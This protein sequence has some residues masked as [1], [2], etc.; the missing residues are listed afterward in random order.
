MARLPILVN[1]LV[2][3]LFLGEWHDATNQVTLIVG[4]FT[5]SNSNDLVSH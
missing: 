3:L 2:T 4:C 1:Q 5:V